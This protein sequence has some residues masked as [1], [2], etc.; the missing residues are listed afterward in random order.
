M[1]AFVLVL[2]ACGYPPEDF[3]VD[4]AQAT[5]NLYDQCGYLP[6]FGFD[7]VSSCATTVQ[8]SYDPTTI[9]CPSYDRKAAQACVDGVSQMSCQQLNDADWPSECA[10][11]CGF[12][13][14]GTVGDSGN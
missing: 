7:S 13:G 5:C 6:T 2:A 12:T 8:A 9:D 10:S 3:A 11:R 14:N 1:L 4:M